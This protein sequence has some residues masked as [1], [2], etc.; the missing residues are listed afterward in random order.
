MGNTSPV[1]VDTGAE[2]G[3]RA[4][5]GPARALLAAMRPDAVDQEPARPRASPPRRASSTTPTCC[6][7]TGLALR[8]VLPRLGRHLPAQRRRRPRGRPGPPVQA[9]PADRRRRAERRGRHRAR[10]SWRC[11]L[12]CA[13]ALLASPGLLLV[14][15]AYVVLTTAY[16]RALKHVADL[17]HRGRRLGL[18]PARG[19]GR[20]AADLF[21]SKW[22][23]ILA[24][25]GSLFIVTAKRYAEL[26]GVPDGAPA[27]SW[28]STPRTTCGRCSPRSPA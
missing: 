17:R 9:P 6:A 4:G 11:S 7:D 25:G 28:P 1:D 12:A 14:V 13:V 16:S 24:G 22:F 19:R 3:R 5:R 27:A 8:R 26:R 10:P 18:L 23:L 15:A 2:T 21:I 20:R